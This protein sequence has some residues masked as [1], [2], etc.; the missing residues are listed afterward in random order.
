M[1]AP[2]RQGH[3]LYSGTAPA[4]TIP[5]A[6]IGIHAP[7]ARFALLPRRSEP[8]PVTLAD[9]RR[10][11]HLF[12]FNVRYKRLVCSANPKPTDWMFESEVKHSAS[13]RVPAQ[14]V[15]LQGPRVWSYLA[16]VLATII[17][18]SAS[19]SHAT[20]HWSPQLEISVAR[21]APFCRVRW[22]ISLAL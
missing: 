22:R 18:G 7:G 20:R 12:P 16:T 8:L 1:L 3:C 9:L 14:T 15:Q 2:L 10:T 21:P 6:P 11:S 17:E 5:R 4:T 19:L 13:L